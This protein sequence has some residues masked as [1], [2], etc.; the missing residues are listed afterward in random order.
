MRE[1][2]ARHA[3]KITGVLSGFDRVLFRGHLTNL[4]H[5]KGLRI[6]LSQQEALLKDFGRFAQTV[7]AMIRAGSAQ[8][9]AAVGAPVRYLASSSIRKEDVARS[10]LA[11]RGIDAGLVCVLTAVEPCWSWQI[12]RSKSAKTQQPQRRM[13]KC[14]HEY[15]YFLDPDFGLMHVR[16]QT[17]MPYMVQIC[18]NGREW[19]ARQLQRAGISHVQADNCFLRIDDMATAQGM[20][21]RLVALDWPKVLDGFA[22]RANPALATIVDAANAP[23]YWTAHQTEWATDLLFRRPAD[24]AAIYPRITRHAISDLGTK[25]VLRFLAKK[26]SP[27]FSGEV[28][29]DYKQRVEGVRVKHSVAQNSVKMYDKA[30]SVLRTET[31]VQRP[32]EFRVV[33]RAQGDPKSKKIPR[34]IRKGVVDLPARTKAS[35]EVNERYLDS[36]AA[37]NCD[38][39]VQRVIDPALQR[40]RLGSQGV[41]ALRPW[42]E[43]DHSLL[44]AISSGNF[45]VAGFR[46]RDLLR[47]LHPDVTDPEERSRLAAR[48][49]RLLRILR[50]HRIIERM[51]G[52]YRYRVTAYGRRLIAAVIAVSES[53]LSKLKQCA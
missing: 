23:Y 49:T 53:S 6:F 43:P 34:P 44:L 30:G 51:E 24:L 3:K 27:R 29:S 32:G 19:L 14:L 42:S 47:Q 11:E 8:A 33:R 39:N 5:E 1:F 37:V 2:I 25:D 35:Q 10:I 15:H 21:D 13:R 12:F 20:M 50:A 41:R 48:I 9:A 26:I 7:T 22:H 31:T 18:V 36:L 4:S 45:L 52:T 38:E 40:T 28:L 16:V 17:W 46:N